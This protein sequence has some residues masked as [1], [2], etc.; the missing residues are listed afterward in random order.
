[1]IWSSGGTGCAA[2]LVVELAAVVV[3]RVVAGG[4]VEAALGPEMADRERQFGSRDVAL[5]LGG[6]YVGDDAVGRINARRVLAELP[7]REMENRV[8]QI[9]IVNSAPI[10]ELADIERQHDVERMHVREPLPEILAMSLDAG[11]ER[12]QV[13]AVGTDPHRAAPAARS[14]RHDLV[15]R[16]EQHRPLRGLDHPFN[17]RPIAGELRLRQPGREVRERLL[18]EG[19]IGVDC[20]E[21][22]ADG[23]ERFHVRPSVMSA[24]PSVYDGRPPSASVRK[25]ARQ[26]RRGDEPG[27]RR[28]RDRMDAEY[29]PAVVDDVQVAEPILGERRDVFDRP[30]TNRVRE[31]GGA[32]LELGD[33]RPVDSGTKRPCSARSRRRSMFRRV[34]RLARDRHSRR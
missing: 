8:R 12:P 32:V 6:Q 9:A 10:L 29:L 28:L 14:K 23:S 13:H 22:C 1:M 26:A 31:F 27:R 5:A 33:A 2:E 4:H 30:S 24:A 3:G 18:L 34:P 11:A 7:A 20:G 17:L 21:P 19:R 15:E 16:I 25:P